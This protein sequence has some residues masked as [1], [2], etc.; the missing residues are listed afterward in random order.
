[1]S[2]KP[3]NYLKDINYLSVKATLNM[4]DLK[5]DSYKSFHIQISN[6]DHKQLLLPSMWP[7]GMIVRPYLE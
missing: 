6:K 2:I 5:Y 4:C 7:K 3:C 1:M